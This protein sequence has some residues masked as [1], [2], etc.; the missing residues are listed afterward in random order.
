MKHWLVNVTK[1]NP[2]FLKSYIEKA[3]I[4]GS[5]I[6]IDYV[7]SKMKVT[8]DRI[9]QPMQLKKN[10][11]TGNFDRLVAQDMGK[12]DLRS[13]VFEGIQKCK[14]VDLKDL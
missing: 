13:F 11:D 12:A 4:D 1:M 9:I 10:K 6:K 3:I 2:T 7:D 5:Y 14:V 8:K